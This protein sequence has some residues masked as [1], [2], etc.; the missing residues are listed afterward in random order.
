MKIFSVIVTYNGRKWYDKCIGSLL[1]SSIPVTPIVVDNASSDGAVDYIKSK[2]PTAVVIPSEE[3][4]GFAKANNIGIRY[5]IDHGA[6]YVFLLNQDAWVEK[7]TVEKLVGSFEKHENIGIACPINLNAAKTAMDFQSTSD[8]PGEYISDLY[9]NKVKDVYDVGFYCAASWMISVDC[10]RK[11]GGFDTSLFK[12]YGEDNNYC[13]RVK[14]HGMRIVV[15]TQCTMCH[16]REF[17]RGFES[18]YRNK[19]FKQ[20]GV[21]RRIEYG[22]ILFDIDMDSFI[23]STRKSIKK[24]YCKLRF[25]KVRQLENELAFF[26]MVKKSRIENIKGGLVWL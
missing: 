8:I 7:D 4:L 14:Y 15:N 6:D 13:Q 23:V 9:M 2:F 26:E 12:H 3:N 25:S 5:A 21:S 10:I 11:V 20:D 17:R 18:E 16:D 19:S 22:N 1:E 24:A